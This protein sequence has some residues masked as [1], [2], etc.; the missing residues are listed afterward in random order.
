VDEERALTGKMKAQ[1]AVVTAFPSLVVGKHLCVYR[2]EV[3][4]K[5]RLTPPL[6]QS[7]LKEV[8]KIVNRIKNCSFDTL[9]FCVKK[10]EVITRNSF[11]THR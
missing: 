2:E 8:V 6:M 9:R 3:A 5:Y 10:L 11:F 7:T 1:W 4:T